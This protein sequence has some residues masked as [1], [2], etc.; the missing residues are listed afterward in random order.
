MIVII[1]FA[2]VLKVLFI[3]R[4]Y[5][6]T[7]FFF[8]FFFAG[9][10]SL[11][12]IFY[13]GFHWVA[14][15]SILQ[16]SKDIIAILSLALILAFTKYKYSASRLDSL[17]IY[18]AVYL[19]VFLILPI[20]PAGFADRVI[21]FKNLVIFEVFY[22]IGRLG[23]MSQ[24]DY[25]RVLKVIVLIGLTAVV[26]NF[27]EMIW[28]TFFQYLFNYG[29]FTQ[30]FYKQPPEGHYGLSWTFETQ[31]GHMR[32]AAFFSDPLALASSVLLSFPACFALYWTQG[33]KRYLVAMLL[34]LVSLFAS[35]SRASTVALLVEVLF[36]S[37]ALD[38]SKMKYVLIMLLLAGYLYFNF[39]ASSSVLE[40]IAMTLNFENASSVGHLL[41][42][43]QGVNAF[44]KDPLGYGLGTSGNAGGTL[45][46]FRLGGENQFIIIAVQLGLVGFLLYIGLIY[47]GIV[48]SVA[49]YK[50]LRVSSSRAFALVAGAFRVAFLIPMLTANTDI[51]LY[52]TLISWWMIGVVTKN[53][54]EIQS[55]GV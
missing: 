49:A 37:L 46:Q 15:V 44:L 30:V 52:V 20:G 24:K 9:Y 3:T 21:A 35:F 38:Q 18:Y 25:R 55:I 5:T 32:F 4:R 22:F 54:T 31:T 2:Y 13:S 8:L 39:F 1:L 19:A 11:L 51:Y 17:M 42:W 7:I 34:V 14:I 36:I 28:H 47:Y 40:F 29:T 50:R 33:S 53:L 12:G 16:Y 48:N 41:Q 6:K 26:V 43:V 27:Y 23:S 10:S 45:S